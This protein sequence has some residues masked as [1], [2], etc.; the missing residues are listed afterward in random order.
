[1]TVSSLVL[2]PGRQTLLIKVRKHRNDDGAK[3]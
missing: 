3:A 2:V 1:M